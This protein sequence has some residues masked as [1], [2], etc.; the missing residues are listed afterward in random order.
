MGQ[1]VVKKYKECFKKNSLCE[2]MKIFDIK[3][4][5]ALFRNFSLKPSDVEK[6]NGILE[7]KIE[8]KSKPGTF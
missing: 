4:K 6:K 2:N 8:I 5:I 7:L 1:K 3:H